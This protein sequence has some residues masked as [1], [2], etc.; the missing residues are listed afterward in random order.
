MQLLQKEFCEG[1][2]SPLFYGEIFMQLPDRRFAKS[3]LAAISPCSKK[4]CPRE[5]LP[6][7]REPPNE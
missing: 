7:F 4:S 6:S 3:K 1:W 2:S 5:I